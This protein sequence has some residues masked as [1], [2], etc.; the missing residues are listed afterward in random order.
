[1]IGGFSAFINITFLREASL[2]ERWSY[3]PFYHVLIRMQ[4]SGDLHGCGGE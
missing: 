4:T 1:M 2:W 3:R